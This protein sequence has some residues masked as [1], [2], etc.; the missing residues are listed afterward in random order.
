MHPRLTAGLRES[1]AC[2]NTAQVGRP[3]AGASGE[4]PAA[5][6]ASTITII[7]AVVP[8]AST[9]SG[10]QGIFASGP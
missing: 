1:S 3:I 4:T 10:G 5:C 8:R 2:G 7:C 9:R 6:A